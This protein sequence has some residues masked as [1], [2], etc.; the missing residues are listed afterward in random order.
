MGRDREESRSVWLSQARPCFQWRFGS[1]PSLPDSQDYQ[2]QITATA[3]LR[4]STFRGAQTA[5]RE[6]LPRPAL[7]SFSYLFSK[8]RFKPLV[9]RQ[10][11]TRM[12]IPCNALGGK[13]RPDDLTRGA[14]ACLCPLVVDTDA[15]LRL[16][17]GCS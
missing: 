5:F 9:S 2:A 6:P 17:L 16:P 15:S 8:S 10:K 11:A 4:L 12:E 13:A 14:R 3:N 1:R 7:E